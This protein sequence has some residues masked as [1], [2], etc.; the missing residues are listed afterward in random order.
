[1]KSSVSRRTVNVKTLV[2]LSSATDRNV[3][4][5]IKLPN[6]SA[7]SLYKDVCFSFMFQLNT[8]PKTS[9]T[10]VPSKDSQSL[11]I[12]NMYLTPVIYAV[13]IITACR[14]IVLPQSCPVNGQPVNGQVVSACDDKTELGQ[15]SCLGTGFITCTHRGNIFRPCAPGTSCRETNGAVLCE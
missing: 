1:M 6:F 8:H 12:E 15:L 3:V 13:A 4:V 14:A 10:A 2:E 7:P 9:R 11:R 5:P